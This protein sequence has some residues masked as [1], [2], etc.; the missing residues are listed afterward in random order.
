MTLALPI[1]QTAELH[2]G[3]VDQVS[4]LRSLQV[5]LGRDL[6]ELRRIDRFGA[7]QTTTFGLYCE[8][9]GLSASEGRSLADLAEAAE[10]RP[11]LVDAVLGAESG[12]VRHLPLEQSPGTFATC[13]LAAIPYPSARRGRGNGPWKERLVRPGSF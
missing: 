13:H 9:V 7:F 11:S 2:Q 8:K 4:R 3:V 10:R 12:D 6:L 1:A 5:S